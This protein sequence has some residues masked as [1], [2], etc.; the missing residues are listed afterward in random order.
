VPHVLVEQ[1]DGSVDHPRAN[2]LNVRSM[3]IFRRWGI[4]DE[5]RLAG[6]PEDYPHCALYITDLNG[7]ELANVSRPH[8][9][10]TRPTMH[11]P[12]RP[13]RCNQYWLDPVLRR[14]AIASG[15]SD[16]RHCT[17]FEHFDERDGK[18]VSRV[19]DTKS[20]AEYE[21]ESEYLVACCGGRSSI[22][23][24]LGFQWIGEPT[25]EYNVNIFLRI[26]DFWKY[27]NKGKASLHFFIGP[28][29]LWATL[30]HLDG[31]EYLRLTVHGHQY[32]ADPE[33]ID[34]EGFVTRMLGRS[35][36]FQVI[37]TRRW[38]ARDLI[39]DRY[40]RGKIFLAGDAA[41]QNTPHGGFGLNTGLGDVLDLGW[42]IAA[43]LDGWGGEGLL[44]AYEAER[45]AVAKRNLA[46][47]L[48]HLKVDQSMPREPNL[49]EP[50]ERG[51]QARE[52]LSSF[53]KEHKP[54]ML[55][56]DGIA[57]GYCYDPSPICV[58]DGSALP[59]D[60]PMSYSPNAHPG[61]RA[62]HAW[63]GDNRS[64]L[65]L[66]GRGFVILKFGN[67]TSTSALEKAFAGRR[68]PLETYEF[69]D[70][71]LATLYGAAL[72]LVR[73]D[74]HVA[75]RGHELPE[76]CGALVDKVVGVEVRKPIGVKVD[77]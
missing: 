50:G 56:S 48:A 61:S 8:H 10:G 19:R 25:L 14:N 63:I 18:I 38:I 31:R 55:I 49:L 54:R 43:N 21:I 27:H 9:G 30:A 17:S 37:S 3:E 42:K 74:G 1:N 57:L 69:A 52:R 20:G 65:D 39:A 46:Q 13:Q 44:Q 2:T 4:A 71:I 66:F 36:P 7:Y 29:G 28:D 70:P 45:R 24:S 47:A 77:E 16:I 64:M 75:W 67:A 53:I 15:V 32:Y 76:N 51:D 5:V 68:A 40:R 58:S 73:P 11:S 23:K 33:S 41:H 59:P 12:E 35:I 26:P 34:V 6:M 60:D 22:R 72:V 62:P